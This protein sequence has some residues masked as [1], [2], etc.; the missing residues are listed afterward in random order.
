M[1]IVFYSTFV[2]NHWQLSVFIINFI[3]STEFVYRINHDDCAWISISIAI[4]KMI[5]TSAATLLNGIVDRN[6]LILWIG[7][8]CFIVDIYYIV[9]LIRERCEETR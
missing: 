3:M 7:G 8:L 5:G 6:M 4:L 9:L 1:G 2:N